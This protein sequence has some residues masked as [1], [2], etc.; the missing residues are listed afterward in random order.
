L[1]SNPSSVTESELDKTKLPA[2]VAIIMDGNG[3]WAKKRLANRVKGHEQGMEVVREIV[4]A[5]REIGI[6]VLTLYAFSTENWQRPKMEVTALMMLLKRFLKSEL[7]EMQENNIRL[8]AIGQTE[9]LPEDV[10]KLLSET[11]A[12]TYQNKGMLLNLALSYGGRAEL[13]KMVREIA[14]KVKA[15]DIEPD[16]ISEEVVIRHL[17]TKDIP[18]PDLMI[19]TSGE[20]RISN[21]LL[22]QLAYSELF[23]T[24]TLWPDFSRAEFVEIL[25]AYQSRERRFGKVS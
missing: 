1:N 3:R 19:R 8:S 20:M 16:T 2:H 12:L 13:V 9:R 11:M 25:K 21:F 6:S 24:N 18:D 23:I 15:G 14:V 10:R 7:P 5:S 22:W 4:R 17:Y